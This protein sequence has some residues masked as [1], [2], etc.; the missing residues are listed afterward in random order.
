MCWSSFCQLNVLHKLHGRSNW[1]AKAYN[2]NPG[3]T[4]QS[5]GG[6]GQSRAS[7]RSVM[8]RLHVHVRLYNVTASLNLNGLRF[9]AMNVIVYESVSDWRKRTRN[10]KITQTKKDRQ[11]D[12]ICQWGAKKISWVRYWIRMW[13]WPTLSF[14]LPQTRSLKILLSNLSQMVENRRTKCQQ[15]AYV[16]TMATHV[17]M[18]RKSRN[19]LWN[20]NRK[21]QDGF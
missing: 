14:S 21:Q 8:M 15:R 9:R 1:F 18:S 16:K 20:Q 12:I 3:E 19:W 7:R 4:V 13:S 2:W 17:A 11:I 6:A 10:N 5:V